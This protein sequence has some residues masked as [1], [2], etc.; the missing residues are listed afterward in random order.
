MDDDC[1]PNCDR[2]VEAKRKST[3]WQRTSN[4]RRCFG[5]R[6]AEKVMDEA[7]VTLEKMEELI[8]L[9]LPWT[10]KSDLP[11]YFTMMVTTSF[12]PVVSVTEAIKTL[13]PLGIKAG[14]DYSVSD[15]EKVVNRYLNR[16]RAVDTG[17]REWTSSTPTQCAWYYQSPSD[18][19]GFDDPRQLE[20][21]RLLNEGFN[22]PTFRYSG[23]R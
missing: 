19:F 16:F 6:N 20:T 13:L 14:G 8:V 4:P 2:P 15:M 17:R 23:D 18:V 21:F 9:K 11:P 12:R 10:A 1:S 22:L 3:F 5:R 7:I